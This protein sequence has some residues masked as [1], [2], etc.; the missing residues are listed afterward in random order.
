MVGAADLLAVV[1]VSSDPG[2]SSTTPPSTSSIRSLG[3]GRSPSRPTSRPAACDAS[4][5]IAT[6]S[7]CSSRLPWEK[8]SRKTSAPARISSA[9]VSTERVAGPIVATIL[10][11]R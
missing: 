8:L 5:A 6:F 9:I 10:V 4:R 2:R 3:P 7:A 1:S 11:R